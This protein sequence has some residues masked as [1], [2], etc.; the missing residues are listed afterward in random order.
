MRSAW[1][2]RTCTRGCCEG[3]HKAA[4]ARVARGLCDGRVP[5][6]RGGRVRRRPLTAIRAGLLAN[7]QLPGLDIWPAM[8]ESLGDRRYVVSSMGPYQQH[9]IRITRDNHVVYVARIEAKTILR[10]AGK[11]THRRAIR[12]TTEI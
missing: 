8:T 1:R 9:R 12:P 6:A 7:A 2:W 4:P 5:R 11:P 3:S 10:C